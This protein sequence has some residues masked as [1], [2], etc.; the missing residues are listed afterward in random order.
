MSSLPLFA[1]VSNIHAKRGSAPAV[2]VSRQLKANKPTLVPKAA[3]VNEI[4]NRIEICAKL[5]KNHRYSNSNSHKHTCNHMMGAIIC[6]Q[7]HIY[8]SGAC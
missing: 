2:L 4:K 8:V 6:I 5:I 7:V 1:A 3:D